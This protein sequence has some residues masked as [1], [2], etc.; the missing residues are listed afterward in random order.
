VAYSNIGFGLLALVLETITGHDLEDLLQ[1]L[2][3][4]PLG[5]EAWMSREPPRAPAWISDVQSDHAGTEIE[6]A[7]SR[8]WRSLGLPW[9][10]LLVTPRGL[11]SLMREFCPEEGRLLRAETLDLAR[12]NHVG[13]SSGG[14]PGGECYFGFHAERELLWSP[15]PWGLGLEL[16]GRKRPHPVP[17]SFGEDS[18]GHVA[19]FGCLAWTDRNTRASVVVVGT[20]STHGGWLLRNGSR[21]CEAAVSAFPPGTAA[22]P[23]LLRSKGLEG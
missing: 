9:A 16:R 3:L 18:Y 12:R 8:Y 23:P 13:D 7:N 5:I 1:D 6:P 19:S 20:R 10:G 17:A 2:V 21:L 11:L 15:C 14:F 4:G 22:A